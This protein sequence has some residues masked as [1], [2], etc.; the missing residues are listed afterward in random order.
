MPRIG[1]VANQGYS[2]GEITAQNF[3]NDPYFS[4]V[5]LL[6]N[7]YSTSVNNNNTFVDSSTNNFSITA[8]GNPTQSTVTPFVPGGWSNYFNGSTNYITTPSSTSYDLGAG[9]FTI[10]FLIFPIS[11]GA[12]QIL[13]NKVAS[14]TVVGSFDIR[15][16][17]TGTI[18]TLISNAS[19]SSWSNDTT[20]TLTV[21]FHQWNHVAFVRVGTSFTRYINGVAAGGYGGS[22]IT[23]VYESGV[24]LN[25]GANADGTSKFTGYMSSVR[26]VK[27]T[28]VYTAAFAPSFGPLPSISGTVLLACQSNRVV[29]ISSV[30]AV[31]TSTGASNV[32]AFSPTAFT[33]A[34]SASTAGSIYFNGSSDYL[35]LPNSSAGLQLT[36]G[37]FTIEC[38]I[39]PIASVSPGRIINN[40]SSST[41]TAASW[42][43]L[44]AGSGVQFLCSTNGSTSPVSLSGSI[45]I[46]SWSH[47][48]GVRIG[49]VFTLY[50]NGTSAATTTQAITLQTAD[51][52]TVGARNNLGSY[53]EF[54]PGYISNARVIKGTGIYNSTFTLS[55]IPFTAITNTQLLLNGTNASITDSAGK[56]A[57]VLIGG[58]VTTT[59]TR[60]MNPAS[61]QFNGLIASG[62]TYLLVP[63]SQNNSLGAGDF[64][65]EF[66]IYCTNVTSNQRPLS[67]GTYGVGEFLIVMNTDG[68]MTWAE[69]TTARVTSAVGAFTTG[70][71]THVA[72][73]RRSGSTSMYKNGVSTGSIYTTSSP[74]YNFNA[75]TPIYV[76]GNPTI[77]SQY[78]NGYIDDLRITKGYARYTTST[79]FSVPTYPAGQS[80]TN[81]A[82]YVY[83]CNPSSGPWYGG[84]AVTITGSGFTNITSVSLGGAPV[85]NL[86]VQSSNT[87]TAISS[88]SIIG[89]PGVK[90][91]SINGD[92]T[93]NSLWTYSAG[94][95]LYTTGTAGG[96][97]SAVTNQY[98]FSW[99]APTGVTSVCV[100][101][102]GGGGAGYNGNYGGGG[103]GGG[104]G[105]KNNITVVPGNSYTLLVGAGGTTT[106]PGGS[107]YFSSAAT[108][109]GGGGTNGTLN[110]SGTNPNSQGVG[111]TYVG[112]GGCNGGDG[113]Y[114]RTAYTGYSGGGGGAG[115][116]T[117]NGGQGA[118]NGTSAPANGGAA[119]GQGGG[120]GGGGQA[121]GVIQGG[122]GGGGVGVLGAGSNGTAGASTAAYGTST[123]GG[124]GSSG[125][126][127]STQ[128]GGSYGGGGSISTGA[129]SGPG[130]PGA[131]RI[132]WGTGRAYPST[133][134]ADY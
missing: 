70:V 56:N 110:S 73:N 113:G 31:L 27:G 57:L 74:Y 120:G 16:S 65:I 96:S 29:D 32:I 38:W 80:T 14:A 54:F 64:T 88:A 7:G 122:Y 130:G 51:T 86:T 23:L 28:G 104:L 11:T 106:L 97:Y 60:R 50:I 55:T 81:G 131:V 103:G 87:I 129:V 115:G 45:P 78:F 127:G 1:S 93:T 40:W 123:A 118:S 111:G 63:N 67:Q 53:S 121:Y 69:S 39:Y 49:D 46:N 101:A 116:Y 124:A 8:V 13:V 66:W 109:L 30:G 47:I 37:D 9:D 3:N 35:K 52:I 41:N 102:V 72:I 98:T 89:T 126:G 34:V 22:A 79:S 19:G 95:A 26:I 125:T 6:M 59:A 58:T 92:S 2:A 42:E 36:T 21:N 68:S 76:G 77:T 20:S 100:V 107:S 48:A 62:T 99:T 94:Q 5:T 4:N 61:I 15:M 10:E 112:D 133:L 90:I 85:Y 43:I 132:I 75:N 91:S 44:Q 108:V 84:N 25:I 134:T 105:W 117:G 71:W 114:Y 82:P 12:E 83:S 33:S 24:T 18:R 17:T 128:T 119:A